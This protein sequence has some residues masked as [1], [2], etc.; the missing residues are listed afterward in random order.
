MRTRTIGFKT[1]LVPEAEHQK[2]N[3][4]ALFEQH[5]PVDLQ[6]KFCPW[7]ARLGRQ[8]QLPGQ[9]AARGQRVNWNRT[10]TVTVTVVQV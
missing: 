4:N 10:M 6:F 8:G 1:E 7:T 2:S 3:Q 9:P 5:K